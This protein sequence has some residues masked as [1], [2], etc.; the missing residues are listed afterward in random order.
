MRVP[1]ISLL[2]LFLISPSPPA[3][4]EPGFATRAVWVTRWACKSPEDV[5]ALFTNL[6]DMGINMV[7]FQVRG[8]CDAFYRSSFEPW[9]DLLTGTL[10]QDPGWDPLAVAVREGHRLGL[11]VHAWVNVFTAWQVTESGYPPPVTDPIHVMLSHPEWIACDRA[12]KPMPIKMSQARDNYAFLS[13]TSK[14]AREYI[15]KVLREI[16]G[17]YDIDGLHLDYVRFPDSSYSYDKESRLAYLKTTLR[18]EMSFSEWRRRE[19]TQFI[20]DLRRSVKKIRPGTKLSAA[21]LQVMDAGRDSFYQD[22]VE[23]MRKGYVDFLVPMIYTT[24]Q[25]SFE[26]RLRTYVDSVG[27]SN[28]IAGVGAYLE[29]FS[30]TTFRAE[31]ETARTY[32]V[33][34]VCIFNSD[35]AM[36]YSPLIEGFFGD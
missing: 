16:V 4:P 6:A 26:T 22:G 27:A 20:G 19:L 30:D 13:P 1:A 9:S 7:F 11:E 36:R 14:G 2:F 8:A 28:V 32:R 33:R 35:Y 18:E 10:G 31:L 29:T 3:E 24:S 17:K 5:T 15:R 34:G 12:G 23:W 21:V 25:T